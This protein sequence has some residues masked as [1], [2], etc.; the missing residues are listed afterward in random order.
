MTMITERKMCSKLIAITRHSPTGITLKW[1]ATAV[2]A[3]MDSIH[4]DTAEVNVTR[5][6]VV[7]LG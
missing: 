2:S 6:T 4:D 7:P 1:V 5:R 3:S